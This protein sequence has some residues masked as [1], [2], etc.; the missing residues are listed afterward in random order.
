MKVVLYPIDSYYDVG[1]ISDPKLVMSVDH[2][3]EPQIL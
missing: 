3:L 2:R 1:L